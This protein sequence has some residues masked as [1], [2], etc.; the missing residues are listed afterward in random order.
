MEIDAERGK[1]DYTNSQHH[2]HLLIKACADITDIP[3]TDVV[4][5]PNDDDDCLLPSKKPDVPRDKADK[6]VKSSLVDMELEQQP[7]NLVDKQPHVEHQ[8][9]DAKDKT[10]V[11][12]ENLKVKVDDK[13]DDALVKVKK[14]KCQ[15]ALRPNYVLRSAERRKDKLEYQFPLGKRDIFVGRH[16][17]LTLACLDI[18]KTGWLTDHVDLMWS[19]RL[20]ETNWVMVSPHFSTCIQAGMMPDYYSNGNMYSVPWRDVK[21]VYFLVNEHK[22]HWCLA[23]L[24]ICNGIVTFYDSLGWALGNRR[25]LWRKMKRYLPEKLTLYLYMHEVLESKG[26]SADNYNITYNYVDAPFQAAL[27]AGYGIWVWIF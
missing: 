27:F 9:D 11:L 18:G 10:T 7:D 8:P 26:I 6:L 24:E 14:K 25:P 21:K 2:L 15:L 4:V 1:D 17:G 20:P 13:P 22:K 19:L 12:E 3:T 23:E 5:P 16:I